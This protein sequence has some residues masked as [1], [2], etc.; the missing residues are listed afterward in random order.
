MKKD[1]NRRFLSILSRSTSDGLQNEMQSESPEV[2]ARRRL[3]QRIEQV[4]SSLI[5]SAP[6]EAETSEIGDLVACDFVPLESTVDELFPP[7]ADFYK[8][9][10]HEAPA[11]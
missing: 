3:E 5:E 10:E 2:E 9:W 4:L 1:R 7:S 8:P 11:A 6:V